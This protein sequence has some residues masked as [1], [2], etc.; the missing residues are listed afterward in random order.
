M[1][2]SLLVSFL[3]DMCK[4]DMKGFT[5]STFSI[6][7]RELIITTKYEIHKFKAKGQI[8]LLIIIIISTDNYIIIAY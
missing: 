1:N 5:K 8:Y 2:V 7:H 4:Q 6:Y 3:I